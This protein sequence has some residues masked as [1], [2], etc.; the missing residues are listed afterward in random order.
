M[1]TPERMP[2]LVAAHHM[3]VL[4]RACQLSGPPTRSTKNLDRIRAVGLS[5][6]L[7]VW[8]A[9]GCGIR[10]VQAGASTLAETPCGCWQASASPQLHGHYSIVPEPGAIYYHQRTP[11]S[12]ASSS[13]S[14]PPPS[15]PSLSTPQQPRKRTC[16]VCRRRRVLRSSCTRPGAETLEL[17][18]TRLQE[19]M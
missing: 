14:S 15:L 10:S 5:P 13:S 16:G 18:R 9:C 1:G 19:S 6:S 12:S 3:R 17:N 11:T 4:A 8:G 7:W 2:Q